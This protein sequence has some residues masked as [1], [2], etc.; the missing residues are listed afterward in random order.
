MTDL[1]TAPDL[2]LPD[3]V[4]AWALKELNKTAKRELEEMVCSIWFQD[5]P[6][7]KREQVK[8]DAAR[9]YLLGM[10]NAVREVVT[11]GK[12]GRSASASH[13]NAPKWVR[14]GSYC[15]GWQAGY[16]IAALI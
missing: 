9:S 8:Q 12:K 1:M 14:K 3:C 5:I 2:P 16:E 13:K 11:L 15:C 4:P 6:A 7:T 10:A